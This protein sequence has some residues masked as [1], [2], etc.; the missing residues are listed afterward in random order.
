M[1]RVRAKFKCNSVE[2]RT[3]WGGNEFVYDAKMSA[4]TGGTKEDE[5]F[6]AAT[7]N[8]SISLCTVKDDLFQVGQEYYV[9][10]TPVEAAA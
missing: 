9:D 2:K 7:P 3:G 5:S 4:V 10:F 6:F 1:K 8:G